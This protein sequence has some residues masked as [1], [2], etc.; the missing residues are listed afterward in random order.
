MEVNP[1]AIPVNTFL[2][3]VEE[4]AREK[5]RYRKGG[6][7]RDGTCD[8]IGLIIGALRRAGAA[9]HRR[10]RRRSNAFGNFAYRGARPAGAQQQRSPRLAAPGDERG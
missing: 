5:P 1:L 2:E 6:S 7:G 3:R 4:I 10:H 9:C 8:C